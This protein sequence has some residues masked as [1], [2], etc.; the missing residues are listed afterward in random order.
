[1]NGVEMRRHLLLLLLIPHAQLTAHDRL[2][3]IEGR[4][5]DKKEHEECLDPNVSAPS[6]QLH[7]LHH[8]VE[9]IAP[10]V[11]HPLCRTGVGG[12]LDRTKHTFIPGL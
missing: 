11:T 1:M 2:Q 6:L 3:P 10:N 12:E 4:A 7:F 5:V 8:L 9:I